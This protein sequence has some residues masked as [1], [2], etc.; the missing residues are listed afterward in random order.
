M[1][2]VFRKI[3]CLALSIAM[4]FSFVTF[5][6]DE[7]PGRGI[8]TWAFYIYLVDNDRSTQLNN[9]IV[10]EIGSIN[11]GNNVKVISESSWS[12]PFD[13]FMRYCKK[14]ANA[15]HRILIIAGEGEGVYG[16]RKNDNKYLSLEDIRKGFETSFGKND[17]SPAIDLTILNGNLMS[18]IE[19]GRMLNGYS[20][21]LLSSESFFCN[22]DGFNRKWFGDFVNN[23]NI[24]VEELGTLIADAYITQ[25]E[26]AISM[27]KVVISTSIGLT[28]VK[29]LNDAYEQYTHLTKNLLKRISKDNLLLSFI[30]EKAKRTITAGDSNNITFSY[31]MYDSVDLINGFKR[32]LPM[33]S[34][35]VL[36]ELLAAIKYKKNLG[37]DTN[38]CGLA[39]YFPS[40]SFEG[41][42][43]LM[44]E[45]IKNVAKNPY[46]KALY[47][48]KIYGKFE[49]DSKEV[50]KNDLKIKLP[51]IDYSKLK[52]FQELNPRLNGSLSFTFELPTELKSMKQDVSL[53][54]YR[55]EAN[56]FV[57]FNEDSY[58]DFDMRNNINVLFKGKWDSI[59]DE[60]LVI[61]PI[62]RTDDYKKS[63]ANAVYGDKESKLY[64]AYDEIERIPKIA[65]IIEED[66]TSR[67]S[68]GIVKLISD[69]ETLGILRRV[70]DLNTKSESRPLAT[71]FKY[72]NNYKI[73]NKTLPDGEYTL[74]IVLE[75]MSGI[76][77]P[78]SN[79]LF[80]VS[81]GVVSQA[82]TEIDLFAKKQ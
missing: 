67:L 77:Y 30:A 38:K 15:D 8:D 68:S 74:N 9:S 65:G 10:K 42:D 60:P 4:V 71:T 37:F 55:R 72:N 33:E 17:A 29:K 20:K 62:S 5:A 7:K 69:G 56:Q 81:K 40:V 16:F 19:A 6:A 59:N 54:L 21:Y 53:I 64:I 2:K 22:A 41:H 27:N 3:L 46:V 79:I 66:G 31:N 1:L 52:K 49:D 78:S 26:K 11:F 25:A 45:Y 61:N 58:M 12:S 57:V 32:A 14:N 39:M 73:E 76:R 47:N 51:E 75:D 63:Y 70:I 50:L 24:T 34:I 36:R 80:G 43:A 18:N 23:T 35:A 44:K 82:V 13:A 48:Y 28:D